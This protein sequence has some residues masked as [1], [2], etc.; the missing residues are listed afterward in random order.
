[1]L[2]GFSR[3]RRDATRRILFVPWILDT[4]TSEPQIVAASIP[5]A[6]TGKPAWHLKRS[7]HNAAIDDLKSH[8]AAIPRTPFAGIPQCKST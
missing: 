5:R 6:A 8:L 3:L 7:D 4:G 2:A 1:M